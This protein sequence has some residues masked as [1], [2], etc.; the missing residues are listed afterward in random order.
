MY[1]CCVL[2]QQGTT[3]PKGVRTGSFVGGGVGW[4]RGSDNDKNG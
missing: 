3:A 4:E 1:I 2:S